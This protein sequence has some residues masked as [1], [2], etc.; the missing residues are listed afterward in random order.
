MD[1]YYLAGIGPAGQ[2]PPTAYESAERARR[3]VV[4]ALEDLAEEYPDYATTVDKVL[5]RFTE[6]PD[7]GNYL[8]YFEVAGRE[9]ALFFGPM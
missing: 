2:T 9:H 4:S 1:A 5:A 3:A 8:E 7:V 6:D